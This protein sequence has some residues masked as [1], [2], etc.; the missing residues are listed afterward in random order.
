[1]R[2]QL[3]RIISLIGNEV[4]EQAPLRQVIHYLIA[5]LA[6]QAIDES[7][8]EQVLPAHDLVGCHGM[9]CGT[10]EHEALGIRGA[11]PA[12]GSVSFTRQDAGVVFPR[13]H[14]RRPLVCLQ[15]VEP[16]L[17][18]WH[19]GQR[20][21]EERGA[22]LRF[23]GGRDGDIEH[24]VLSHPPV[25]GVIAG[26][27]HR[28]HRASAFRFDILT[29]AGQAVVRSVA[30]DQRSAEFVPGRRMVRSRLGCDSRSAEPDP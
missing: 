6:F 25:L 13:E 4:H 17:D 8:S 30:K 20:A 10:P 19:V 21:F 16:D 7:E 24:G 27:P 18:A 14:F 3:G 9:V 23:D 11:P 12:R 26:I 2:Q 29:E 15:A 22:P 5:K 28:G 1:M